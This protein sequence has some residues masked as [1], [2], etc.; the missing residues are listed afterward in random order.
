MEIIVS[1]YLFSPVTI[2]ILILPLLFFRIIIY[3]LL[4]HALIF[5]SPLFGIFFFIM[6]SSPE[7][8]DIDL[9]QLDTNYKRLQRV[10]HPDLHTSR[11]PQEREASETASSLLNI[12]HKVLRNPGTRAQY[13]LIMN[14]F[15]AI[16]EQVGT[17]GVNPMLLMQVMEAR[18]LISDS[19]TSLGDLL[20]L[21]QRNQ[22]AIQ[23]CIQD[24]S[25]E[26]Q[27]KNF[28]Q[29]KDI[30][31]ALQYYTK[32]ED[33]ISERI[34]LEQH[35]STTIANTAVTTNKTSCEKRGECATPRKK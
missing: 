3:Y 27:N 28:K 21:R 31:I 13:L 19:Q 23:S 22:K 25:K 5:C 17:A 9:S 35:P 7:T 1:G 20:L 32:I 34:E 24:L 10:A 18:E 29:A 14:G 33:E 12:A 16:G 26:F 30:T 2:Y 11:S 4:S 6:F 8:F 15:D